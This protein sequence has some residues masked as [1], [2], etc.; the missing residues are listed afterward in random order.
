MVEGL[1]GCDG[2]AELVRVGIGLWV[3]GWDLLHPEYHKLKRWLS[4][5]CSTKISLFHVCEK[6]KT[7]LC[8]CQQMGENGVDW[9]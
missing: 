4:A 6:L 7:A 2:F 9:R 1:Y 3:D 8:S 5:R